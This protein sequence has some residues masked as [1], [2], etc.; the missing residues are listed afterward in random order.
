MVI[1]PGAIGRGT[2]IVS[3]RSLSAD[4][5]P[6]TGGFTFAVGERSTTSVA[7]PTA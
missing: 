5:H 6:I 2:V 3:W 4:S 7:V 1:T